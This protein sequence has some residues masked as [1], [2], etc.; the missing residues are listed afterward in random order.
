MWAVGESKMYIH[1][2]TQ[3]IKFSLSGQEPYWWETLD[4]NNLH[5]FNN[6]SYISS[7]GESRAWVGGEIEAK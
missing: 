5:I 4:Y 1:P 2:S 7:E 3:A 6:P